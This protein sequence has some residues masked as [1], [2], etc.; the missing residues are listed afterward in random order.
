MHIMDGKRPYWTAL[1]ARATLMTQQ[2]ARKALAAI[3]SV[4]F[5]ARIYICFFTSLPNM[6][7]D[8]YEYY[9][10]ADTLLAGGYTNFFPNGYPLLVVLAKSISAS[11][12]IPLLL[13]LNILLST[14]TIYF[15]YDI[16]KRIFDGPP[17]A[18]M[19]A[20]II[21]VFPS[22]INCV[23]W[24][25]T[26]VP[27]SFFLLGAYFFYYRRRYWGSGLFFGLASVI[28][29]NIGP[30][31]ILLILAELFWLKKFNYRVFLGALLPILLIASYCYWMTGSFAVSGNTRIN[32]LYAVTA[33]GGKVDY[34]MG[35]KHPEI[36]TAEKALQLYWDHLKESPGEFIR[37]RLA[38]LWELWGCPSAADGGRGMGSRILMLTGNL[39]MLI[40]GLMG[41]WKNRN[42]F[43]RAVLLLPFVVVT[44][45]H[46]LLIA[47]PRYTYPVEPF[48]I[49][50]AAWLMVYLLTR[51][52]GSPF[53]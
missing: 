19:A 17:V 22:Q 50:L 8:S 28:R 32:I 26:E 30:V 23:R 14:L 38:N 34:Y 40:P 45:I 5:L 52:T 47:I 1:T 10:Q 3:L 53:K 2:D 12:T 42:I 25:T 29:T 27:S 7:V 21:A 31:F 44:P 39:F 16:A 15:T 11:R 51:C 48:M 24:L 4:G 49:L 6:H 20:L 9:R 37:Q 33:S 13:G 35:D 18:L 36:N 43:N 41:W 46:V